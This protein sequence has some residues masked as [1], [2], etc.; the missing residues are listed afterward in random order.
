VD[1]RLAHS[2]EEAAQAARAIGFPVV[3]KL[4]SETLTHK[5]DVGGVLLDL[6]D[7]PAVR[8][9]FDRVRRSVAATAGEGHFQGVAVQPM[10]RRQGYELILGSSVDPQ[11]GPVLL[12][13]S[14][15]QLVEVF[16]DRSLA[17]PP[18]NSTLA[19]RMM[20]QTK[21]WTALQG[22]RGRAPVDVPGLQ[23]LLVRFAELV[24]EQPWIKEIDVNP[25]LASPE[26]ALALD[27]RVV[28]HPTDTPEAALP[29]A[30][31]RPYPTQYVSPW[32]MKN[33]EEVTL[34]PIRPE[35]EPLMVRFHER[36]SERSVYLRYFHPFKLSQ[37]VA[38]ERLRRICYVDYDREMALVAVRRQAGEAEVVAVARLSRRYGLREGELAALVSDEVHHQGLGSELYR[39]LIDFA[40]DEG[41]KRVYCT[42]LRENAEMRAICERL[43]FTLRSEEGGTMSA[44]RSL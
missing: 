36:L 37:R 8:A 6:P 18:L 17:L 15:G 23:R 2:P 27:A 33:G 1:T 21:V 30:A 19:R 10:V 24:I 5:S 7:E 38:H 12:F 4:H 43:G 34:R 32:R 40:R 31:I 11:F 25:L 41:F 22:V 14:G 44:E 9:A 39:R 3:V 28:L 29:R 13:G 16:K 35:D 26:G 20:E 42:L